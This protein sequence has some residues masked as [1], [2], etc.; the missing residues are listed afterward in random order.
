MTARNEHS[1]MVSSLVCPSHLKNYVV[2]Y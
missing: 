2:D 1:I